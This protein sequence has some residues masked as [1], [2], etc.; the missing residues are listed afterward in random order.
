MVGENSE[1]VVEDPSDV[2]QLAEMIDIAHYYSE[3]FGHEAAHMNFMVTQS[4]T[5][6]SGSMESQAVG[7]ISVHKAPDNQF[8]VVGSLF[9]LGP[10]FRALY[11]HENGHE[12]FALQNVR[13]AKVG[14]EL[15]ESFQAFLSQ[16]NLVSDLQ[17][18]SVLNRKIVSDL[19]DLD[20]KHSRRL[21]AFK[22]AVLFARPG[23]QDI[24]EIFANKP[25]PTSTFY[26]FLD[27][28]ANRIDMSEW[29]GYRG[30]MGKTGEDALTPTYHALWRGKDIIFHL[31]PVMSSEQ[32]RRLCGN[33][34]GVLIYYDAGDSQQPFVPF[35]STAMGTVPHVFGVVRPHPRNRDFYRLGFFQRPAVGHYKPQCPPKEYTGPSSRS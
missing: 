2:V 16:R 25:S 12:V 18:Y 23:Q 33:D 14:A 35:S 24:K 19:I 9:N 29:Q 22:L 32:H 27:T 6:S 28:V 17:I 13:V 21:N 30:D 5:G 4:T 3:N 31:A 1:W 10:S 15:I 20:K 34:I 8:P 26:H 7:I 11:T